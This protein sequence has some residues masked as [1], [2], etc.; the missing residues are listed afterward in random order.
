MCKADSTAKAC[1]PSCHEGDCRLMRQHEMRTLIAGVD[2]SR[3]LAMADFARSAVY[4]NQGDDATLK[5][6]LS[7]FMDWP[8]SRHLRAMAQQV[9]RREEIAILE[10]IEKAGREAAGDDISIEK[11]LEQWGQLLPRLIHAQHLLVA[12]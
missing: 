10:A 8:Y 7:D 11:L 3:L 5:I 9:R 6:R 1:D 2:L 12:A 4:S